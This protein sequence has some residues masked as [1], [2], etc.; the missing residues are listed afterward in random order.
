MSMRLAYR[1]RPG[2]PGPSHKAAIAA[3][4][5]AAAAGFYGFATS[6]QKAATLRSAGGAGSVVA[7]EQARSAVAIGA[8]PTLVYAL[9]EGRPTE[10]AAVSPRPA[11][12]APPAEAVVAAPEDVS[13]VSQPI[14]EPPPT[15]DVTTAGP[16]PVPPAVAPAEQPVAIPPAE[17]AATPTP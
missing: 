3:I 16:L 4:C 7:E 13:L 15:L 6:M 8:T 17:P 10:L 9:T 1:S 5:L 11:A 12:V 2:I 14:V